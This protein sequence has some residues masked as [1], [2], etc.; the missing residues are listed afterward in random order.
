M[1]GVMHRTTIYL[2]EALHER[3]RQLADASGRTQAA[4]IRDAVLAYTTGGQRPSSIG[5]GQ[6]GRGDLS[7]QAEELLEGFGEDER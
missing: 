4:V 5:L 1:Y 7:E 6:S 3:V 2:D